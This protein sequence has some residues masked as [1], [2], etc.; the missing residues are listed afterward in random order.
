MLGS[1]AASQLGVKK[2]LKKLLFIDVSKAYFHAPAQRP[3]YVVLPDEALE[4]DERG[5]HV[6]GRLNYSLYGTRDAAQNW[7]V[8]YTQFLVSLGFKRGLSSP[9]IFVHP[10]RDM[11]LVV[12][13]DDFTILGEDGHLS[14]L[15]SEFDKKFKIKVRGILGPDSH[16]VHEITL[17]NRVLSWGS[18][19]I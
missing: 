1:L 4:P 11:R 12:H 14:W 16:D 8:A 5:G 6:V 18:E 15:A 7:E 10:S 3:V 13:G 9:C 17:L 2:R 19:G